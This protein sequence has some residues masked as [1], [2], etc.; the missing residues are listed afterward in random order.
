[1]HSL[2]SK[3]PYKYFAMIIARV[4]K[5][6]ILLFTQPVEQ[7]VYLKLSLGSNDITFKL[8]WELIVILFFVWH[9]Y[10][11]NVRFALHTHI[12]HI[13]Y[14]NGDIRK[15]HIC[16]VF[17]CSFPAINLEGTYQTLS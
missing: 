14:N 11:Y 7:L 4:L 2:F 5:Y 3:Y 13:I 8:W 17:W 16:F 15:N 9:T 1:M 12:E 6:A 10:V